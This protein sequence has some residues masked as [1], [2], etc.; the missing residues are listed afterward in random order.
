MTDAAPDAPDQPDNEPENGRIH[1]L[2]TL[3]DLDLRI[4]ERLSS[5][6]SPRF[7]HTIAHLTNAANNSKLSMAMTATQT[8]RQPSQ[9]PG[10]HPPCHDAV[11]AFLPVRAHGGRVRL[12]HRSLADMAIRCLG[13]VRSRHCCRL[14][15]GQYRRALPLRRGSGRSARHRLGRAV[16]SG[17]QTPGPRRTAH[18][19]PHHRHLVT[20]AKRTANPRGVPVFRLKNRHTVGVCART[21]QPVE[22]RGFEPLTPS[23]R[24]RCATGLRH[25]PD[26]GRER[27][28]PLV[29]R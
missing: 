19:E 18:P 20:A 17:R 28:Y 14:L 8:A 12:C 6:S 1:I 7:D 25:S 16:R 23:M 11:L 26:T 24:T 4:Y 3:Y 29:S 9:R 5:P 27:G 13:P 2:R 15:A 22:L 21:E 10:G